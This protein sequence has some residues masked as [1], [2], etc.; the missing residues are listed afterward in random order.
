MPETP[1]ERSERYYANKAAI[2]AQYHA[3]KEIP[4]WYEAF[5][6]KRKASYE[7]HRTQRLIDNAEW[8]AKKGV[9]VNRAIFDGNYYQRNR[10][11]IIQ[12]AKDYYH[13]HRAQILSRLKNQ[14]VKPIREQLPKCLKEKIVKEKLE[15][16]KK[17]KEPPPPDIP[18]PVPEPSVL[19][20]E[21]LDARFPSA[22]F[23]ITWD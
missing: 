8:R 11:R 13:T 5:K 1:A 14:Y 18:E 4:G 2:S 9:K 21:I 12:N 6:A 3:N 7:K 22:S 16:P 19:L 23:T 10:E 15:K 17:V 20:R